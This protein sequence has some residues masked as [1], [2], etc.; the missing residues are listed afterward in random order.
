MIIYRRWASE[1]Q[2]GCVIFLFVSSVTPNVISVTCNIY[3]KLSSIWFSTYRRT[4]QRVICA[5]RPA[6]GN[7]RVGQY[8]NHHT[9][10]PVNIIVWPARK[11]EMR[12]VY[13]IKMRWDCSINIKK[14]T[15]LV[16]I[17]ILTIV[18]DQKSTNTNFMKLTDLFYIYLLLS[19]FISLG[20]KTH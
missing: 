8:K 7:T 15:A 20:F 12:R 13:S 17:Y 1:P 5:E 9:R 16:S 6:E 3:T 19:R 18:K 10:W 4:Q 2:H 11:E 14:L